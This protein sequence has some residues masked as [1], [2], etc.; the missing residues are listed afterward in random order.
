[1]AVFAFENA[2]HYG[3][4]TSDPLSSTVQKG[5][6]WLLSQGS[7]VTIGEQTAGNPNTSGTGIG[8][9]WTGD[10]YP[11][12]ET[13]MVLMALIASSAPTNVTMQGPLGVRTYK[14]IA[15]DIDDYLFAAQTDPPSAYAGGW[16]YEPNFN[17]SAGGASDQSN[18][19]WPVFAIAAAELWGIN[20][21]TWVLNELSH[22]I[23]YD[24]DLTGKP[25]TNPL[26]GSFGYEGV[27][28]L[29]GGVS[30]A[31]VGIEELTLVGALSTNSSIIAAEGFINSRW[32]QNDGDWN[33]NLGNLYA[34]YNVMK[35]SRSAQPPITYISLYNGTNGVQWYNGTN[36]YADSLIANQELNGA[37]P[38]GGWEPWAETDYG[39]GP[40]LSTALALLIM[41][42]YVVNIA[43]TYTLTITVQNS[44]TLAPV[45][46]ASVTAQGPLTLSGVTGSNGQIVFTKVQ[47]GNYVISVSA[48]GYNSSTPVSVSVTANTPY[49]VSLQSQV[50]PLTIVVTPGSTSTTGGSSVTFT[51]LASGG[52]PPYTYQYYSY[53]INPT[54]NSWITI[55]SSGVFK[56][57]E[58]GAF[59]AGTY[60]FFVRVIDASGASAITLATLIVTSSTATS[61]PTVTPVPTVTPMPTVTPAPTAAPSPTPTPSPSPAL[62]AWVSALIIVIIIIILLLIILFA[63]L[64]RRKTKIVASAGANG[65]ISPGGTVRVN[66]GADQTFTI[67]ADLHYHIADVQVD[68]KSVGAKPSYTF[69]NVKEDHRISVTFKPD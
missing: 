10:G 50:S 41:E 8:I 45:S 48:T 1:M 20:P 13:S 4:N 19:G 38:N 44:A 29:L 28:D 16:S 36:E 65:K 39:Y 37:W 14:A 63:W 21:P 57:T 67:A 30:E 26:Y 61:A 9:E 42:P 64:R 18:T 24:Q 68:G 33:V 6:N 25:T 32:T 52:T 15:R 27:D 17:N 7:N 11:D 5:L 58:T 69:I 2:G 34:M 51:A 22:W 56:I 43:T 3:W 53:S 35:S 49:T 46:G 31:A 47:A 62:A 23:V 40:A 66:R 59:A 60:Y 12:Y 55:P 54:T